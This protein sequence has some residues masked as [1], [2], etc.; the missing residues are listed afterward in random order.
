MAIS[1]IQ[2]IHFD[3]NVQ[4]NH[5]ETQHDS[6]SLDNLVDPVS[7]HDMGIF[8][9]TMQQAMQSAS[10][11]ALTASGQIAQSEATSGSI[12]DLVSEMVD[13]VQQARRK[14]E[15]KAE[16][17]SKDMS[18]QDAIDLQEGM[19][20]YSLTVQYLSKAVSLAT[21]SVDTIVHMQ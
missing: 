6:A 10:A 15:V 5:N 13:K 9:S 4:H 18:I 20:S 17:A 16:K 14:V 21:K 7:S 8:Q 3:S 19:E 1:A 2:S 11:Q 12:G